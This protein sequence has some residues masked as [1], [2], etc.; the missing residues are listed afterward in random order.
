MFRS[1]INNLK[2]PAGGGG[3][4]IGPEMQ[5]ENPFLAAQPLVESRHRVICLDTM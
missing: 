2:S 4:Q 1:L 5:Y 3:F